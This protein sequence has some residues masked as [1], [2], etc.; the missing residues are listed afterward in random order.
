MAQGYKGFRQIA[1]QAQRNMDARK[2]A[3]EK[4]SSL[5]KDL[6]DTLSLEDFIE[7]GT[8]GFDKLSAHKS[9][10]VS[11]AKKVM[12]EAIRLGYAIPYDYGRGK[13]KYTTTEKAESLSFK[14]IFTHV[15]HNIPIDAIKENQ[16]IRNTIAQYSPKEIEALKN[17]SQETT[18]KRIT[19][20][21][22]WSFHNPETG[23]MEL[24]ADAPHEAHVAQA[25]IMVKGDLMTEG[26]TEYLEKD[27][28][29]FEE[30]HGLNKIWIPP[31][32]SDLEDYLQNWTDLSSH[33][34]V[35]QINDFVKAHGDRLL[36]LAE[37][38]EKYE[39]KEAQ[40]PISHYGLDNLS[41]KLYKRLK[42]TDTSPS[43]KDVSKDEVAQ[44][45]NELEK[46]QNHLK[47][48]DYLTGDKW[49]EE[50][51]TKILGEPYAT[52]DRFNKPVTKVRGNIENI[53]KGIDVPVVEL[54]QQRSIPLVSEVKPE[55]KEVSYDEVQRNNLD[56]VIEQTVSIHTQ[57]A[58]NEKYGEQH[59]DSCPEEYYCFDDIMQ[60][61][62]KGI[63]EDEIKAWVWYKRITGGYND[64]AVILNKKN[65]WSKYVIPLSDIPN[66]LDTWL[67]EG[68]VCYQN[69]KYI[70]AV[71]YYAENIYEKQAELLRSKE[72]VI[73]KHGEKQY[74]RQ[75][76]G[77][78]NVKPVKLT[79]ADPEIEN[80]LVINP[81]SSFA[82]EL[83]VY[84]LTDGTIYRKH[85]NET[86]KYEDHPSSLL[87][88]FL[89]WLK[90]QP[91][92]GFKKSNAR[93][94]EYYFILD[95]Q[96]PRYYDKEER[97]RM[98]RSAKIEGTQLFSQFLSEGI[99]RDDQL[100]IEQ[101]WNSKYNGYVEIN[102][103]KI[104][105]AF[106]CSSTFKNKPL[107]I[108]E[109][110]REGI[111]FISVQGTGCVAYD[112]GVGKTMTAILSLG[113]ALESGQCRRPLI[114]VPNQTYTNWIGEIQGELENGKVKL[115]GVLPQYPVN[116]LY[117]L[118][119]DY[120]EQIT[121]E[122]GQ[123]E[124]VTDGSITVMTYEG[125]NRLGF[126]EDTWSNI[127]SELYEILNQGQ[128][129]DRE[130]EKL[131]E[132][133]EEL[134]G[135]GI[136][137]GLV[138]IEELGFDYLVID[139]AHAMKKSFTQVRGEINAQGGR[140]KS[141]YEIR[142]GSPSMIAL[143]GFM[144]SQYILRN[145]NM[146]NVLLL[147]ATP[148]TNSP[149]EIYS[150]LALIGYQQLVQAGIN[151]IKEFFDQYIKTSI[152][153]VINAKLKPERKEVVLGFNNLV[154]LQQLIFR[155]INYKTGEDANI[156]RPN[157]IVLPR[158][159]KLE[160]GVLVP[161]SEKERVSTNLPMSAEQR[162]YMSQIEAYVRG[163]M[164]LMELCVNPFGFADEE[165]KSMAGE[166]INE[167][168]LSS[169]DED[170]A[171]VLR[172]LSFAS[173]LALSPYLYACNPAG[174]PTAK[175]FVEESPKIFYT[176]KCI[177]SVKTFADAHGLEMPG[178]V[179]YSNAGVAY[180]KLIREYL[181]E[182]MGFDAKEIGI[183][184]SGMSASR[185]NG[186]KDKFNSG[187]V[188]VLIGSATI[189]E[190]IN[191]QYRATDL[192]DLWLDWN[193][194]DVKQ[195]EGRIWRPGN[196]YANVRITFPLMENSIDI[197]KFQK[198]QE[199]TSRINEIWHRSGRAN[200]LKLEEINPSELKKGLIT[201]PYTL[202]ELLVLE[203]K[204]TMQ[205]EINSL[206]NQK[207]VLQELHQ[208][209]ETFNKHIDKVKEV[210]ENYKPSKDGKARK[211]ETVFRVYK[212]WLDDP[213]TS[214]YINDEQR[215]DETR[216]ANYKIQAGIKEILAPRG[217]GIDFDYQEV[218][219][220]IETE[221][222]Q[223]KASLDERTSEEAIQLKAKA[224]EQERAKN[225]VR[226]ATVIE[227]AE[228]FASLNEKVI[229]EV[230]LDGKSEKQQQKQ[231]EKAERGADLILSADLLD[232]I[233]ELEDLNNDL[234]Q[235]EK[236]NAELDAIL[237][238]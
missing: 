196:R 147:T 33:V 140:N 23:Y 221:I 167:Q 204:E 164:D 218:V 11:K 186:V 175:Q 226:T 26:L 184:K 222:E 198:L 68:V 91:A 150:M 224:I 178:Q 152:E 4:E 208:A 202:A 14:D 43:K 225:K 126:G 118:G 100:R 84:A 28:A 90:K 234:I 67:E 163:E 228:E 94:I 97:R 103:H 30:K 158:M 231:K 53:I 45:D 20:V 172:A 83:E 66:H 22:K 15:Y 65:G 105:V 193:P 34:F 181:V 141:A 8:I 5:K 149:L 110:Q 82:N 128:E 49:F 131:F 57:E 112:V 69:G 130:R 104:P 72:G 197:F 25:E 229:T 161:L 162:D 119:A 71:L 75:F 95:R 209:R 168:E 31:T 98:I 63:S 217:L 77:L 102:Y 51:P 216:K 151:N 173:Q 2:K 21:N 56:K 189:K 185:K 223:F 88:A 48:I 190:G 101:L 227:R 205:D 171:R 59:T 1:Q 214:T 148:F 117:N 27:A 192:Y 50:N 99:S 36:K 47:A 153:L 170:S 12:N 187:E 135:Q 46:V 232:D 129:R 238:A 92:S 207:E 176:I 179:I 237:A 76:Q 121:T 61:Y 16:P 174:N 9:S 120:I 166:A 194:T 93:N 191:L 124:K 133:I 74:E 122:A 70:P 160:G 64:E 219:G 169:E 200:T 183:I 54:P 80:R 203:D 38:F 29:A 143:R 134:M 157:K 87:R 220:K 127:K 107:F 111:G 73:S 123:V 213:E 85:N 199:K 35:E 55:T 159:N 177:E 210:V 10:A 138:N 109:A 136:K 60:Q 233:A 40:T 156:Q 139:E 142:S 19:L 182:N 44:L 86:G 58:I 79:L 24:K 215:F 96:P 113:Q 230:I 6:R 7:Y 39:L 235:L 32:V 206:E 78:E 62:N 81:K 52:T 13:G 165:D 108:R 89:E 145:N 180:F 154:A 155:F 115:S 42:E 236:M 3:I 37:L 17:E 211:I 137:G 146:R 41:V 188:K 212:Q 106:T 18:E 144:V 201:D 116:D 132:K 114:I 195:L 125:F